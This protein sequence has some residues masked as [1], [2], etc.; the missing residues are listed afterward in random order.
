MSHK[1]L[2]RTTQRQNSY[3]TAEIVS[4]CLENQIPAHFKILH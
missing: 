4:D 3:T 1:T 2:L